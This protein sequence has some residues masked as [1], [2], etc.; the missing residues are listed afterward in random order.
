[1]NASG[2]TRLQKYLAQCGVAS[3]REAERLIAEGRISVNGQVALDPARG[4]DPEEDRVEVDGEAVRPRRREYVLLHKPAGPVCTQD[5]PEGR[6]TIYSLL[7]DRFRHLAYVGR[8]DA[9][10][11]GVLL[12]TNDGELAYRLTRP[13]FHVPK[14]YLARVKGAVDRADVERLVA[15][16]VDEGERLAATEARIVKRRAG[17]AV[18][19]L[20]LTEGKNREVRRMLNALGLEVLK[21]TRSRFA[22][23]EIGSLV[24][25]RWRK[26]EP[27]E[28]DRL[29][30]RLQDGSM[31]W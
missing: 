31:A 15:G 7:P 25:G 17:G 29:R 9:A 18:I 24:P 27:E 1:M 10:T 12:L 4:I 2:K 22:G 26:L 11:D 14:V 3:R 6:A 30:E 8:L 5:D 21:L 13:E 19:E 16:I 23:L 20:V 28:V